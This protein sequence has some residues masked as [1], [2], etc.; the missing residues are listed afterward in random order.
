MLPP[1]ACEHVSCSQI[2]DSG[3]RIPGVFVLAGMGG[4][5]VTAPVGNHLLAGTV[6]GLASTGLLFPLDLIKTHYQVRTLMRHCNMGGASL[7]FL[8]PW[9]VV[10]W[11]R[12]GVDERLITN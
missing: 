11:S 1:E 7:V 10:V 3:A 4:G 12:P 2:I 5:N 6:A 8:R 9:N